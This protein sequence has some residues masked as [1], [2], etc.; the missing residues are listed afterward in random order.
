MPMRW[1]HKP[2]LDEFPSLR[3]VADKFEGKRFMNY[4]GLPPQGAD[5][6]LTGSPVTYQRK[7]RFLLWIEI[8][9]RTIGEKFTTPT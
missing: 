8:L 2:P 3:G 9:E 1:P 6:V 7:G 4:G 5:L